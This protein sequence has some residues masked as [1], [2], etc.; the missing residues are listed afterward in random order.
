MY[1]PVVGWLM[2]DSSIQRAATASGKIGGFDPDD[3]DALG[4]IQQTSAQ[5]LL[6]HV[7][8]D[9]KIRPSH[10][11]RLHAAPGHRRLVLLDGHDR[12]SIL[13]GDSGGVVLREAV[14]GFDAWLK[15]Q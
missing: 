11:R 2:P 14:A 4:A 10:S 6:I 5:A 3:A 13:A 8:N 7:E 1:A 15:G 9:A 12:D